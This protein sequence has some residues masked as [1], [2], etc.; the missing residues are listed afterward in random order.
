MVF[1][2]SWESHLCVI[3]EPKLK[4][5]KALG[6]IIVGLKPECSILEISD[7]FNFSD[8]LL[9]LFHKDS[10]RPDT[11]VIHRNAV[12][13]EQQ[14]SPVIWGTNYGVRLGFRSWL[15]TLSTLF[16]VFEIGFSYLKVGI[17]MPNSLDCY[18]NWIRDML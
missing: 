10:E 3:F 9:L 12:L 2:K 11:S 18:E 15:M 8:S 4:L 7:D 13:P 14:L 17:I 1:P 5:Q 16:S 6:I